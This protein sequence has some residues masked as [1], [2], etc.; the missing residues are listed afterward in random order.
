MF[1]NR[2][3]LWGLRGM[4]KVCNLPDFAKNMTIP[5]GCKV[6]IEGSMYDA[7][8]WGPTGSVFAY[9]YILTKFKRIDK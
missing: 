7:S 5:D 9:D 3:L 8:C 2:P 4:G 6:Y 1:M